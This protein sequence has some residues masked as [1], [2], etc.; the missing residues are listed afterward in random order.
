MPPTLTPQQY[1]RRF[2]AEE[3]VLKRAYCTLFG[4]W[5]D[6]PLRRCRR[7]RCCVGDQG[8]C[9][10]RRV[11]EVPLHAQWRARQQL[12]AA[13]PANAGPPER[14][15]RECMPTAFFELAANRERRVRSG[16]GQ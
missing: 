13:T 16:L 1:V 6:C 14:M 15:A 10:Q 9:L 12:I 2:E 3:A 11:S 8:A 5:R 4:F 7:A